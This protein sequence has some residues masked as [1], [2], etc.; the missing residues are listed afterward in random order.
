MLSWYCLSEGR[1][2]NKILLSSANLE[3]DKSHNGGADGQSTQ[4]E[5]SSDTLGGL[6]NTLDQQDEREG[7]DWKFS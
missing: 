5:G 3:C 6:K 7:V 1:L 2:T 4:D